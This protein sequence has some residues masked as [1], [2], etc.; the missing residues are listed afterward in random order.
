MLIDHRLAP[1]I[2]YGSAIFMAITIAI[3][4]AVD[5]RPDLAEEAQAAE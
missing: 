5:R 2:F 1:W 4:L 3:A